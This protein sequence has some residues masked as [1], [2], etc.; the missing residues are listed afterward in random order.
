M[1]LAIFFMESK[2]RVTLCLVLVL[3]AVAPGPLK[4]LKKW[5]LQLSYSNWVVRD[6]LWTGKHTFLVETPEWHWT[7]HWKLSLR[8]YAFYFSTS[9]ATSEA[10]MLHFLNSLKSVW[11][12]SRVRQL[13]A[14]CQSPRA[15]AGTSVWV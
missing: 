5:C 10:F 11:V 7:C 9:G 12:C 2:T 14:R 4:S 8:N 13:W 1:M 15:I 6:V 3:W